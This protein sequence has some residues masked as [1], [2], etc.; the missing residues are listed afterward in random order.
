MGRPLNGPLVYAFASSASP[1]HLAKSAASS[2]SGFMHS[3][4]YRFLYVAGFPTS[5]CALMPCF[6]YIEASAAML[7][8]DSTWLWPSVSSFSY[9]CVPYVIGPVETPSTGL[10]H[11][12]LSSTNRFW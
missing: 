7:G 2:V 8:G 10:V 1:W 11:I 4:T 3:C 9:W 5:K 6:A 12:A